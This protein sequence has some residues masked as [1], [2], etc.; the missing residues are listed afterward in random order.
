[1]RQQK[2]FGFTLIEM[3]ASLVLMGL[4]MAGVAGLLPLCLSKLQQT[5]DTQLQQRGIWRRVVSRLHEDMELFPVISLERNRMI[6]AKPSGEESNAPLIEYELTTFRQRPLLIRRIVTQELKT[7]SSEPIAR[8]IGSLSFYA[9]IEDG[10]PAD[11]VRLPSFVFSNPSPELRGI[12]TVGKHDLVLADEFGRELY[13]EE[14]NI[15]RRSR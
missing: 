2:R 8:G 4:L 6:L 12:S 5:G 1:M 9:P 13:H 10:N 7:L 11:Q 14:I 3:T 15:R